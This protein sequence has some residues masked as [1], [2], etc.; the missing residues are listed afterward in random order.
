MIHNG[1]VARIKGLSPK[2]I[3]NYASRGDY[4]KIRKNKKDFGKIMNHELR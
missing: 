1:I 2:T 4:Y 3:S